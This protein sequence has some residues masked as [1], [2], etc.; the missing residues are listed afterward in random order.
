[1]ADEDHTAAR[2]LQ[3]FGQIFEP[4]R[5]QV[6]GRLVEEQEIVLRAEQSGQP[7][8][9]ALPHRHLGKE[10]RPVGHR[11]QRFESGIDAPVGVPRVELFGRIEGVGIC[12][13]RTGFLFGESNCCLVEQAQHLTDVDEFDVDEVAHGAALGDGHFLLG[14][15]E[16]AE[17]PHRA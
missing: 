7:D 6:V 13:R 11:A 1:M 12:I 14:D 15:T 8:A 9:V 10:T 4:R 2:L 5:V 17:T 16:R 3:P